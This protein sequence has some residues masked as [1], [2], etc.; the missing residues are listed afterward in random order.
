MW[1]LDHWVHCPLCRATSNGF[2]PKGR[3][4]YS[5]G[6]LVCKTERHPRGIVVACECWLGRRKGEAQQLLRYDQLAES[7]RAL[8]YP[9]PDKAKIVNAR[10]ELVT[11]G[12]AEEPTTLAP[13]YTGP[14][15]VRPAP[16]D[17]TLFGA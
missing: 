11:R 6:F 17:P 8:L 7:D 15:P 16:K 4:V 5:G 10:D 9:K 13:A 1:T 12:P 3:P 14:A 2:G